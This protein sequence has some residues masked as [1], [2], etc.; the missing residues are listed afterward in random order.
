MLKKKKKKSEK[1]FRLRVSFP[2]KFGDKFEFV[3]FITTIIYQIFL[4]NLK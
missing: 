4:D 3:I 1:E 2:S